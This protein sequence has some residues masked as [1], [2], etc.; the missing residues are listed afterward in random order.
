MNNF[1]PKKPRIESETY[2]SV[3]DEVTTESNDRTMV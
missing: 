3:D 2:W 1:S